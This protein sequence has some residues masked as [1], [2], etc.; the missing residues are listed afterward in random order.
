MSVE[1]PTP[2]VQEVTA[3]PNRRKDIRWV[4]GLTATGLAALAWASLATPLPRLVYN[5][6]DSVPVGWYRITPVSAPA[7]AEPAAVNVGST[8]LVRLP[9]PA[10]ALAAQRGYLAGTSTRVWEIES[11]R[12]LGA[13]TS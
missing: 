9:V 5:P 4:F 12:S 1:P 2:T 3:Q 6:S 7:S 11:V 10:A 13:T 8:V